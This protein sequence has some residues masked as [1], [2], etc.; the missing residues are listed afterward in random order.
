MVFYISEF[1]KNELNK[2]GSPL[3]IR[4]ATESNITEWQVLYTS[5]LT[6]KAKK[7][8]DGNLKVV[9]SGSKGNQVMLYDASGRLLDSKFLR[10]NEVIASGVSLILDGYLVDIGEPEGG[11]HKPPSDP[12]NIIKVI[13][14]AE[15]G[16]LGPTKKRSPSNLHSGFETAVTEWDVLY[17]TQVTQKAKR[18]NTG[19]LRLAP[20][21]SCRLK[22]ALSSEDGTVLSC[23]FLKLSEGVRSGIIFQMPNYLVEV[24]DQRMREPEKIVC[25]KENLIPQ[26]KRTIVEVIPTETNVC[27]EEKLIPQF[28]RSIVDVIPNRR[29]TVD[30]PSHDEPEKI[31]C[32]KENLIPQFKRTIVEVIPTETNACREEKLTPQL[33]RSIVDDIPN[34]RSTVDKPSHAGK[35]ESCAWPGSCR[36]SLKEAI[37]TKIENID[38]PLRDAQGILSIL[39]KSMKP[40]C[41]LPKPSLVDQKIDP[42]CSDHNH[43]DMKNLA[44]RE[45]V[46][47]FDKD[48]TD[49][50]VTVTRQSFSGERDPINVQNYPSDDEDKGD[51]KTT[52]SQGLETSDITKTDLDAGIT[53]V[54]HDQLN[55]HVDEDSIQLMSLDGEGFS[56][57]EL[58][59]EVRLEIPSQSN[60]DMRITPGTNSV[61]NASHYPVNR[62]EKRAQTS[63]SEEEPF[64]FSLGF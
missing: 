37:S 56:A 32:K 16:N 41:S 47:D 34:R 61:N 8:H 43:C 14:K 7:Y 40:E 23:K 54:L 36:S 27:T 6:Q 48:P 15:T 19:I 50:L 20:C 25:K 4:D 52:H 60:A 29:S 63:L 22:A 30:K 24:G 5:Q 51:S 64:S 12:L 26:F 28:K 53:P 13:E 46:E 39:K 11:G 10:K 31:V 9:T 44:T 62:K 2:Y 38:K 18:Y 33:K 59:A 55:A 45:H 35:P 21:G 3:D 57:K 1:K 49:I 58:S 42:N 17:T